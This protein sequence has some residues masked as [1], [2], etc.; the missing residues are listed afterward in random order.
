MLL[1]Q[2]L[3]TA[4]ITPF[5][6][7]GSA[8][9]YASFERCLRRQEQAG[10]G[11]ILMGSTG[12]S[13][14]LTDKERREVLEFACG[15]NLKTQ[16]VVGAPS[17][18]YYSALEWMDYC[19]DK[20]IQGY[21]LTTPIY[22]KPGIK[23]QTAWFETRLNKAAHPAILYN[24]PGRAGIRL[25]PETVKN[26]CNHEKFVAIKDSSGVVD[27]IVEYQTAAPNVPVYCGDDYMMAT[28]AAEG[29]CGLISVAGN[30]WPEETRRYVEKCLRSERISSKIWWHACKVLFTASNPIPI[31]ALMKDIGVIEHDT[32]RLPLST[33]DLPSRSKLLE[34]HDKITH[35]EAV[36]AI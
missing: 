8:V 23:G 12:E 2:I 21:L 15:L 20:P 19:K 24:I 33:A 16:L 6:A 14:S 25:H 7:D 18:N 10:N 13:L 36:R 27:S 4:T 3:W 26:L 34:H 29:S 28:V 17:H 32:V 9:D 35:W 1:D 30:A 31:K 5:T 22:T 11:I